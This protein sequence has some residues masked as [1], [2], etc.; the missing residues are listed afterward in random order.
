MNRADKIDADGVPLTDLEGSQVDPVD[1]RQA[2]QDAIDMYGWPDIQTNVA[3][4]LRTIF[5]S[6]PYYVDTFTADVTAQLQ[7]IAGQGIFLVSDIAAIAVFP[8]NVI[9]DALYAVTNAIAQVV[10]RL[11]GIGGPLVPSSAP[12]DGQPYPWIVV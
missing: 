8:V 5:A 1:L 4:S 11:T 9:G 3:L 12:R 7:A 10:A 6:I 2:V